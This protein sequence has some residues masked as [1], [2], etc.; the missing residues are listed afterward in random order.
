MRTTR[1][2]SKSLEL[3]SRETTPSS[4]AD[5]ME[6]NPKDV[7]VMETCPWDMDI[8]IRSRHANGSPEPP[9]SHLVELPLAIF[10]QVLG[11]LELASQASLCLTCRA[12]AEVIG[13]DCLTALRQG[14]YPEERVE[15]LDMLERDSRH[16]IMCHKC[17]KLHD[18]K[19]SFSRQMRFGPFGPKPTFV[20]PDCVEDG[21]RTYY[22]NQF[23]HK[24][25]SS[26]IFYIA[27]KCHRE[28][29][30]CSGFLTQLSY[31]AR[32]IEERNA[33]YSTYSH[34]H[35]RIVKDEMH[36][37]KQ[38]A[39]IPSPMESSAPCGW[40]QQLCEHMRLERYPDSHNKPLIGYRYGNDTTHK[41]LTWRTTC[42]RYCFMEFR[43]DFAPVEQDINAMFLT[44]WH[45]LGEGRSSEEPQVRDL[46]NH[47]DPQAYSNSR[48]VS[49]KKGSLVAAFEGEPSFKFDSVMNS[50]EL[51]RL[52]AHY[53]QRRAGYGRSPYSYM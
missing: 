3:Y 47:P 45:N 43:L 6:I 1:A 29:I 9:K 48:R 27:M 14:V 23:L 16:W 21:P 40:S 50:D 41:R 5:W 13:S 7:E 18:I 53:R 20:Y 37:R 32:E 39:I 19:K 28:G 8:P 17:S 35:H 34:L 42:C 2:K 10:Q 11:H 4:E 49:F 46:Y 51:E 38:T 33:G 15:F 44:Q 30:D 25:W 36:V 22:M 24:Q 26:T 31:P 12:L 52:V